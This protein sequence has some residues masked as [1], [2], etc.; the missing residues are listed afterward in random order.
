MAII[1]VPTDQPTVQDAIDNA[2]AGDTI[3][4]LVGTFDGFD[5]TVDRLKI[6]GCGI[7]KTIIF[8]NPAMGSSNGVVVNGTQTHL[9]GF[10]VQGYGGGAGV[11]IN[12]DNN[13]IQQVEASFNM[14][15][16]SVEAN[17]NLLINNL[18]TFNTDGFVVVGANNCL[19]E[20]ESR[21]NTNDGYVLNES[22]M[23]ILENNLAKENGQFGFNINS[24][25]N[26]LFGNSALKNEL[27]GILIAENADNNQVLDN[28]SCDNVNNGI[29][30]SLST[31]NRI[32][33][34]IVR[35]NGDPDAVTGIGIDVDSDADFNTISFNKVTRNV[36][37][38]I[39][40]PGD[41]ATDNT[42]DG[43]KCNNSV[44]PI[45]CNS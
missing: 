8:G 12:T 3:Q 37:L 38:D 32:D 18:A 19:V 4:I 33:S 26:I 35:K 29:T 7:G 2:N 39:N 24:D 40:A 28:K 44:P 17:D 27:D 31:G 9:Q 45:I 34:N 1:V 43:N 25:M 42:F 23:S 10:T 6:V 20:N 5:I 15:G 41:A 16:F 13:V 36:D 30:L 22:G 14:T 21:N 11:Q